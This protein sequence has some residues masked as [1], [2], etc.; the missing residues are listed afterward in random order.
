[1]TTSTPIPQ[2]TPPKAKRSP[3]TTALLVVLCLIYVLSPIDF[4]PDF[5][6]LLGWIDDIGAIVAAIGMVK[7][8]MQGNAGAA[9]ADG[10]EQRP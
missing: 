3:Q 5:I 2:P 9:Q 6:P 8:L 1:M 7:P 10:R 4:L